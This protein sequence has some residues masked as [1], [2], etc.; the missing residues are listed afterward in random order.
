M[1]N[2]VTVSQ[3]SKDW[4]LARQGQLIAELGRFVSLRE[5]IDELVESQGSIELEIPTL[6]DVPDWFEDYEL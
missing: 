2:S 3:A 4:L 6:P 5:I 1:R